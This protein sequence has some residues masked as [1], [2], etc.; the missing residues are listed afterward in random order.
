MDTYTNYTAV[1]A[2]NLQYENTKIARKILN[3]ID[4]DVV[5]VV[6]YRNSFWFEVRG[7]FPS[8]ARDW[9]MRYMFRHGFKWYMEG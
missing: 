3:V 8:Y 4:R 5:D 2:E 7:N 9:I 1:I 6:V